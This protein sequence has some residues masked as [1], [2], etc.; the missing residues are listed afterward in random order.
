MADGVVVLD[1]SGIIEAANESAARILGLT[2][3]E[4]KGCAS[5]DPRGRAIREDGSPFPGESHPARVTLRT[6]EPCRDVIMGI[7]R[8]DGTVGWIS[9]NTHPMFHPGERECHS[10]VCSFA[11][12]T[13]RRRA[14][15]ELRQSQKLQS[16]GTLAGGIAHELNNLLVPIIGLTELTI[17]KMP[18]RGRNRTNLNNVLAAAERARL[19]VQNILAFSRRDT[20]NRRRVEIAPLI[21]EVLAIVRPVLPTTIDIRVRTERSAP[22]IPADG[23]LIHQVLINLMSNAAAAMGLK[24]GLLEINVSGVDL[25][26]SFC[27]NRSGLVPGRYA[28]IAVSDT[29][30]G[31]DEETQ[32]RIFEPFF[33]T[34]KTGDGTGMGLSVV[35]GIVSA[36]SGAI[37]VES[38]V[39]RGTTFTVYFPAFDPGSK[40]D[41]PTLRGRTA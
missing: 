9:I 40:G 37:D 22:D 32:R 39:G 17:E 25:A 28:R 8:P 35:H 14:E 27:R 5:L 24:G 13:D 26:E 31:M 34:K 30:H 4:I 10:V 19:L 2:H 38:E 1:R 18:E 6:G 12:V 36:H 20:P 41:N 23:A 3:D 33:T 11:E 7:Q 16:I 21:E 29:G 15:A